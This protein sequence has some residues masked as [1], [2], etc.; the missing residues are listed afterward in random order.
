[1]LRNAGDGTFEA[2]ESRAT[3][4]PW[5]VARIGD[6][7]GNGLSD[8]VFAHHGAG[9]VSVGLG[10]GDGTLRSE[11]HFPVGG[12]P[13]DIVT[14][15]FDLDGRLDVA[16]AITKPVAP[17]AVVILLGD[18]AGGLAAFGTL[19]FS[20][21]P[22]ALSTGDFDADGLLDLAIGV[23]RFSD[24]QRVFVAL[25]HGDGSFALAS[26]GGSALLGS[27][28]WMASDDFDGD[29]ALDLAIGRD[30]AP[31]DDLLLLRGDGTGRYLVNEPRSIIDSCAL[32]R[33]VTSDPTG[34]GLPEVL[35]LDDSG[36]T[37]YLATG[38]V[39]FERR[40]DLPTTQPDQLVTF[41]ADRDGRLDLVYSFQAKT[42]LGI[43]LGNGDG[44]FREVP[45]L[46]TG[47][48]VDQL[49]AGDVNR[50]G[51]VDLVVS[52]LDEVGTLLGGGDGTFAPPI[53]L[54]I[55]RALSSLVV[56][57]LSG[58]GA[59]DVVATNGLTNELV[60]FESRGDG[61]LEVE[62]VSPVGDTPLAAVV[63]DLDHDGV[64]DAVVVN[65]GTDDVSILLGT[66]GGR[67]GPQARF[68]VRNRPQSI[69]AADFD[70]DG[71]LDL[72]IGGQTSAP[73]VV[74]M[75]TVVMGDGEGRFGPPIA[76]PSPSGVTRVGV[77]DVDLDGVP[78]LVLL[79]PTHDLSL[80]LGAGDGT[81]LPPEQTRT[82]LG[83]WRIVFADVDGDGQPDLLTTNLG[84]IRPGISVLL[85]R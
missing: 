16:V 53:L 41:D 73:P 62:S 8:V 74:G 18:G 20:L 40:R 67:F 34:D 36:V 51:I 30:R 49:A 46:P 27:P 10:N 54:P 2:G 80:L 12:A 43:Q 65:S 3:A 42:S 22:L 85:H 39:S 17:H 4:A 28:L 19:P 56:T 24:N 58:D 23:G 29:G 9:E 75:A 82:G 47:I 70:L 59:A 45:A 57:D 15:D 14:G 69:A 35:V 6:L 63:S 21:A 50:D 81:F 37:T 5:S 66:G 44:S 52:S 25:G 13:E 38:G 64:L 7:D 83:P 71:A 31:C 79:H 77:G 72:V 48:V 33:F 32:P 55:P 76:V 68:P 61:T 11:T 78:D 26:T 60:V 1:V 84:S